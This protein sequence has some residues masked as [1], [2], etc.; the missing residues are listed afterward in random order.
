ML[1]LLYVFQKDERLKNVKIFT[2]LYKELDTW[3]L[4]LLYWVTYGQ[5]SS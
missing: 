2:T 4:N 3:F 1:K 5:L